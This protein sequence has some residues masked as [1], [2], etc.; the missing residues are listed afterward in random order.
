M[1][2][3]GLVPMLSGVAGAVPVDEGDGTCV[4]RRLE[5]GDV[6]DVVSGLTK[7]WATLTV[8]GPGNTVTNHGSFNVA[9]A[10]ISGS[11]LRITWSTPFDNSD[12]AIHVQEAVVGFGTPG[13]FQTANT[14]GYVDIYFY[15]L[16]NSVFQSVTAVFRK[17]HITAIGVPLFVP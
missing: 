17:I 16:A 5:A 3:V 7:A 8:D 13:L 14:G 1:K 12:Y 6:D 2:P 9:S 4:Q 11:V 10:V 15:D